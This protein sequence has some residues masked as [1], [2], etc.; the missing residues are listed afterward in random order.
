[1]IKLK[2]TH[3]FIIR[4]KPFTYKKIKIK[5]QPFVDSGFEGFFLARYLNKLI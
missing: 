1:M 3:L 4:N 5:Q 2:N